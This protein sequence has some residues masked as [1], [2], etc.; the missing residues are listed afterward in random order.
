MQQLQPA[1][2]AAHCSPTVLLCPQILPY[3][4]C[5]GAMAAPRLQAVRA[6]VLAA[7]AVAHLVYS[8]ES[9]TPAVADDIDAA[10]AQLYRTWVALWGARDGVG[11]AAAGPREPAQ[12]KGIRCSKVL[13]AR[14]PASP[15]ARA[16]LTTVACPPRC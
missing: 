10:V 3:L 1:P 8:T 9:V 4:L 7:C 16:R 14:V 13:A 15:A 11:A 12:P 5:D 6:A 2:P